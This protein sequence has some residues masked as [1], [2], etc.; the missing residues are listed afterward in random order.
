MTLTK[1]FGNYWIILIVTVIIFAVCTILAF[2]LPDEKFRCKKGQTQNVQKEETPAEPVQI[3][4]WKT[5]FTDK[6][7]RKSLLL[8]SF[9]A[10]GQQFSG[11]NAVINYA[12]ITFQDF[13]ADVGC[14]GANINNPFPSGCKTTKDQS[15]NFGQLVIQGV[16]FLSV[17]IAIPLIAKV[18]RKPLTIAGFMID[19]VCLLVLSVIYFLNNDNPQKVVLIVASIIYII[20][21][22]IAPGP[23]YY[24][25]CSESFPPECKGKV[26]GF[27][28]TM[29]QLSFFIVVFTFPPLQTARLVGVAY[30]MYFIITQISTII[31]WV[32]MVE[33]RGKTFEEI[34]AVMTGQASRH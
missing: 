4:S 33:T 25:C 2:F 6:R 7:Y 27:A 1:N 8:G 16:N 10:I 12:T 23:L 32:I 30:L 29:V 3:I 11:I 21:F 15:S 28:F 17:F 19:N 20:G 5:L 18:G 9:F 22:E 14:T 13:F 31:L 34:E 26:L 24:V